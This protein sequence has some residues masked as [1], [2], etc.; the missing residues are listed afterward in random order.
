[1]RKTSRNV[2]LEEEEEEET[3]PEKENSLRVLSESGVILQDMFTNF[4]CYIKIRNQW[5][6][7]VA[8]AITVCT[9][10]IKYFCYAPIPGCEYSGGSNPIYLRCKTMF[11][12]AIF[13][14]SILL[15]A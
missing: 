6:Q 14:S 9:M 10:L 2:L 4:P 15:Y 3:E 12:I 1:M 13:P 5:R 11:L 8:S 7:D